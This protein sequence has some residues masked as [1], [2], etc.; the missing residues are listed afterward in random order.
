MYVCII[1]LFSYFIFRVS[2]CLYVYYDCDVLSEA[3]GKASEN[4][5]LELQVVVS[6]VM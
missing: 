6:S 2:N 3:R 1:S 4:V 5:E